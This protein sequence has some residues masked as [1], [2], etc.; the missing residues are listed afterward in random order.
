[1]VNKGVIKIFLSLFFVL[2]LIGTYIT[3]V[4]NRKAISDFNELKFDGIVNRKTYLKNKKALF[5]L[6]NNNWYGI[7]NSPLEQY[8]EKGDSIF[9]NDFSDSVFVKKGFS[10]KNVKKFCKSY[11]YLIENKT[12]VSNLNFVI[13]NNIEQPKRE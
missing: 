6:V 8:I 12:V 10:S 7:M 11:V 1:M 5:V 3:I 4:K 9:K 2:L 13:K